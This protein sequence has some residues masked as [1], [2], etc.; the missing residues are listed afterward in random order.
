MDSTNT[1]PQVSQSAIE[2]ETLINELLANASPA[3]LF[4]VN[5]DTTTALTFGY[6]GGR[7]NGTAAANGTVSLTASTTNYIVA[8]RSTLAVTVSTATTNWNDSTTYGR[9]YKVVTGTATV[10]SYEDHRAGT[11]GILAPSSSYTP[12]QSVNAQTGTTYTVVSGDLNKLVTFSNAS[13]IAVTLPQ[14][15]GSFGAGWYA[16]F[17]NLGVGAVTITPTTSTING[18]ATLVLN[19]GQ[20]LRVVS[21]GT[22]YLTSFMPPGPGVNA[23]TGTT[24]T[25]LAGDRGKLVTHTNA[26]A[27]AGT[28]PQATGAF[29]ANWFMFVQNRGAGT[30]TITPTTSTIDGSATLALTTGQGALI[31][32]D[33]T[34]YYTSRGGAGGSGSQKVIQVACSDQ[35]TALTTG[36]AK[37]TF[38]MPFAMTLT[39]VRASLN[40]ASSS[41]NP[42][43]DVNEGGASIFSTTLTI[44]SGEKTST[45][46]AT[47]AVIS[48]SALADDAEITIDIDTAGTG[49]KGLVVTLIGT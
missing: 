37:V 49:A 19:T 4:G 41:G 25:Y 15:T 2:R 11:G 24:Y 16:D 27:I 48:D 20:S 26:S 35:T 28:L 39:A 21:D 47:P 5:P 9:L 32:S 46:A 45:T 22:N 1:L 6:L 29:G 10:T 12:S 44:D 34:N 13:S 42:A 3:I 18:G 40:T 43:I 31:V 17:K 14:A 33:G 36:T 23:Q 8:D 7:L 38:R 30:L